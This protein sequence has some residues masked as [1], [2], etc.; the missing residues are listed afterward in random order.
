MQAGLGPEIDCAGEAQYRPLIT[1][2]TYRQTGYPILKTPQM[3]YDNF[4]GRELKNGDGS[5]WK[6]DTRKDWPTDRRS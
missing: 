6:S 3:S 4:Q 1:D 2:P 5:R